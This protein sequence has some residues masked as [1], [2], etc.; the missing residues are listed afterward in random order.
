MIL[1]PLLLCALDRPLGAEEQRIGI[2]NIGIN[3]SVRPVALAGS[4]PSEV[5]AHTD[6]DFGGGQIPGKK[7]PLRL[8]IKR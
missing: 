6:A 8:R 1:T 5:S 7:S 2:P 3:G 4:C